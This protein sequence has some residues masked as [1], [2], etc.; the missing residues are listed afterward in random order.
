MRILIVPTIR[1][2]YKN[3]FEHCVDFRLINFL[4]K[5]FLKSTIE[6]YN[7]T[8]K[9]NYD[10]VVFAGGNNSIINTNSDKIR[11]DINKKIYKFSI[12]NNIKM[13]GIC[14]G[15]HFLAKKNGFKIKKKKN[16]IGN[17]I[18]NFE[19][20]KKKFKKIVNSYHNEI[21]E[22]KR[23]K[24][25]NVFGLA[26]DNTVEAFHIKDKKILGIMWHPERYKKLKY[27]DKDLIKKFYATNNIICR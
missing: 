4:K 1:E 3:Q 23:K 13:L 17:H 20:K 14:H 11:N 27:F 5:I 2:I 21:I 26:E 19:F 24:M 25:I 18:V 10:L 16:H 8:I 12:K 9:N 7:F 15:F 6:I 22:N